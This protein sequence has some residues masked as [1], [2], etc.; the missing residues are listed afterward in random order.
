MYSF[1]L[2]HIVR[3]S[4]GYGD[5]KVGGNKISLPEFKE[6]MAATWTESLWQENCLASLCPDLQG[7][8][9]SLLFPTGK[10]TLNTCYPAFCVILAIHFLGTGPR[11][12]VPHGVF[13]HWI[14]GSSVTFQYPH[15]KPLKACLLSDPRIRPFAPTFSLASRLSAYLEVSP[16]TPKPLQD[17]FL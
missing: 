4:I 9:L 7:S 13:L 16:A 15:C 3:R 11:S 1:S 10:L 12:P 8:C 14:S 5:L 2:D 6:K 17:I